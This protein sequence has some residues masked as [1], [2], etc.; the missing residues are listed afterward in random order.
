M[1]SIVVMES[2]KTWLALDGTSKLEDL[3]WDTQEWKSTL[4]FNEGE[5]QFLERLLESHVFE[6]NTPN[7]FE[8]LQEYKEK[9]K[10]IRAKNDMLQLQ[11]SNHE[12]NLGG[13]LECTDTVCDLQ[14]YQT[15]NLL[16]VEVNL[17]VETF[18]ELKSEI[19]NYAGGMLKKR[20][21]F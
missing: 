4:Q 7:L 17:F 1:E 16:N 19:F 5:V 6:A 14:Y 3:H 2:K 12:N 20:K 8:R 9:L 18:Q 13:I 10:Q 21:S 15:H 11:I